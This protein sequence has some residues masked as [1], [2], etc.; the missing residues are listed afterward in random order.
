M[1]CRRIGSGCL[2]WITHDYSSANLLNE[3]VF[4]VS[5]LLGARIRIPYSL[6]WMPILNWNIIITNRKMQWPKDVGANSAEQFKT[7]TLAVTGL[8][9]TSYRM[10]VSNGKRAVCCFGALITPLPP[11]IFK[12][13]IVIFRGR[14]KVDT[15][16]GH[17]PLLLQ[18]CCT[19]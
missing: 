7:L 18:S 1:L 13:R 8:P 6:S 12:A 9:D 16:H 11:L 4:A 5:G 17:H 2:V 15:G 10:R 14:F 3:S 19:S